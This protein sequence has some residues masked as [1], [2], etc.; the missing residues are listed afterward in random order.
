MEE[1]RLHA[2]HDSLAERVSALLTYDDAGQLFLALLNET[3]R[4]FRSEGYSLASHATTL[5]AASRAGV[6]H[7]DLAVLLA[8]HLHQSALKMADQTLLRLLARIAP[9]C[10]NEDGR[11]RI[12]HTIFT[13][14]L[15][16]LSPLMSPSRRALVAGLI[17]GMRFRWPNAH[18]SGWR[19]K[20][21][22]NWWRPSGMSTPF[23]HY[24]KAIRSWPRRR[25]WSLAQDE[26]PFRCYYMRWWKTGVPGALRWR[27]CRQ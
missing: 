26:V 10:L 15:T 11:L 25:C 12:T 16:A 27:L 7:S 24:S 6:S 8:P 1:L 18:T 14:T 20:I 21:M 9:F 22:S 5:I 3:D 13:Q 17:N 19:W 23:A 4:D 2:D